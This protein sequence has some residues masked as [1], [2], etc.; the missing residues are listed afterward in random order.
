MPP[1]LTVDE[2]A[3]LVGGV[4]EG[5]GQHRLSGIGDLAA[6]DSSRLSFLGN[7]RYLKAAL[8]SAAGAI[9]AP[10]GIDLPGKIAVIRVDNPSHA[11][12][13]AAACFTPEP[14]RWV[15]GIHPTAV[16]SA[17]ARIG[18]G[19][20]I[21][22]HAVVEDGAVIASGVHLGAGVYIGHEARVGEGSFLHARVVVRE[23]CVL[24]ARVIVHCG[25]VIGSDGFGYEF[26]GGRFEKIPQTGYVQI[27]DDVEI[28]ANTAIDRGRFDRTWIQEGCKIDNLVMIAHNV[29]VG[30]H[31]I[32]VAQSGISGSARLG[33][34][35][36]VAGQ[37][38][39]VGHVRVGDGAKITGQSGVS[40]DVPAG[41]VFSGSHARP[42]KETLRIEALT[43]RLPELVERVRRLEERLQ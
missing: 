10:P 2:I 17:N 25:A 41:A 28:G 14:I 13:K 22:P 33:N 21:G 20:H 19:V 8:G 18:E 7:P 15:P 36:T 29:V 37:A 32:L 40:K 26:S 3:A 24:G 42:M 9:L 43:H 4:V 5:N 31:S 30:R 12:A 39:I 11:F 1:S 6:A 16:V 35:V 23:R 38:G 34:Y 27:D